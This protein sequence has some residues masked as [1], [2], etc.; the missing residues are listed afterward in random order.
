MRVFKDGDRWIFVLPD[1]KNLQESPAEVADVASQQN[2]SMD[3]IYKNLITGR[4][5]TI[6]MSAIDRIVKRTRA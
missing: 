5:F 6:A 2:G 3:L 1:F 4:D